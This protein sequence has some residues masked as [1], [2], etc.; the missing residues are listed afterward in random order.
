MN[1]N[2]RF[3]YRHG[4]STE[5]LLNDIS[6][7]LDLDADNSLFFKALGMVMLAHSGDDRRQHDSCLNH[8]LRV[9]LHVADVSKNDTQSM[10]LALLHDVVEDYPEYITGE[11]ADL[12][13][14]VE[15]EYGKAITDSLDALTNPPEVKAEEREN[16]HTPV[17]YHQHIAHTLNNPGAALVKT[18]D[19]CD[20]LMT[21]ITSD[22]QDFKDELKRRYFPVMEL[23]V[24]SAAIS[25]FLEQ[26]AV[27]EYFAFIKTRF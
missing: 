26:D 7:K 27:E 15:Q 13:K 9:T 20:N 2:E 16:H 4:L 21:T 6:T 5:A 3:E 25:E 23:F 11:V 24:Q 10:T 12:W 18:V 1:F 22:N 19:F 8:I 14:Y 17:K